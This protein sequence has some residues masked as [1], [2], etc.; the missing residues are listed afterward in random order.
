MLAEAYAAA[1]AG[2]PYPLAGKLDR[3]R[4]PAWLRELAGRVSA[5]VDAGFA[6]RFL[7][8]L[9][10]KPSC[11]RQ[12]D[13]WP[14]IAVR[15]LREVALPAVTVDKWGVRNAINQVCTALETGKGLE[16]ARRA[17][18]IASAAA[19]AANAANAAIAAAVAASAAN[20][21]LAAAYAAYAAAYTAAWRRIADITIEELQK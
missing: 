5:K 8:A 9:D 16:E 21:A 11:G 12:R 14:R 3:Y 10:E 13:L 17:A 4:I 20:A 6:A 19:Y 2:E 7:T 1:L 18:Y 15:I